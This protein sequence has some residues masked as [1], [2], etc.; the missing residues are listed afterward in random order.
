MARFVPVASWPGRPLPVEFLHPPRALLRP[1]L[2]P[3]QRQPQVLSLLVAL[4]L[5]TAV[6]TS[7][8]QLPGL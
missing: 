1:R 2:D 4:C 8:S 5:C 6:E 7:G 3:L